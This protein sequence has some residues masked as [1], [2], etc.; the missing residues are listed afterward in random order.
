MSGKDFAGAEA[1]ASTSAKILYKPVG[2][3]SSIIAGVVAGFAFKQIW[4]RV[5]PNSEGDAPG[6]LESEFSLKEI[7]LA[8]VLQGAIFSV[9]KAL[10][11]RQG[12][13]AFQ[14]A[15]GDWPGN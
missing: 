5:S 2:I 9:V 15:T 6:P 14:K 13:R 10:V 8:A 12:A 11:Q 4:K 3:V 7:L 1:E